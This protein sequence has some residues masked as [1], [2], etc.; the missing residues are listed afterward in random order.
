L[1]LHV[2]RP[3]IP[4]WDWNP[5]AGQHFA[6]PET[7]FVGAGKEV[8]HRNL[9]AS[10]RAFSRHTCAQYQKES[11]WIRVWLGEAEIATHSAGAS[12]TNIGHETRHVREDRQPASQKS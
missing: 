5:D 10:L 11:G 3:P 6:R 8:V 4:V 9:P 12:D 2:S 1:E 7:R